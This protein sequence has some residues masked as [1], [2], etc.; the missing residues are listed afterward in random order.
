LQNAHAYFNQQM[1]ALKFFM[2]VIKYA[3]YSVVFDN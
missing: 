2:N 1:S 3:N